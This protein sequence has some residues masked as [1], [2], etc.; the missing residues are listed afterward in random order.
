LEAEQSVLGA[1]ILEN[2]VIY[3]VSEILN[4]DEFY[5]EAHKI[6]YNIIR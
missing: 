5:K 4:G 3:E 6:L 2:E 1:M